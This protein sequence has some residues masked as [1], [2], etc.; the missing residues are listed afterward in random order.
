MNRLGTTRIGA[1]VA[2]LVCVFLVFS[3]TSA[4]ALAAHQLEGSFNGSDLPGGVFRFVFGVTTDSSNGPSE[5]DLYVG[6]IK[7]STEALL[8]T[9]YKFDEDGAYAGVELD[10]SNT[11]GGSFS[12][13]EPEASIL[14]VDG[15]AVDGSAGPTRGD[16]YVADLK[17][18]VVDRF[19]ESGKY[20]CQITGTPKPSAS[21]C[22]GIS[23]SET[24]N[25]G[26]QPTGV[27]VDESTGTV[28]VVDFEHKVIDKFSQAGAFIGQ[29]AD[30]HLTRPNSIDLDSSGNLYVANSSFFSGENVVKFD[31]T[32][33]FDS[34]LDESNPIG[35]GVDRAT[36]HVYVSHSFEGGGLVEYDAAGKE[37]GV[38]GNEVEG[39][40]PSL[41]VNASSGRIYGGRFGAETG[42]DIYAPETTVPITT[43]DPAAEVDE[44]TATIGGKIDPAEGGPVVSC[45][46]EYGPT[47]A[48]GHKV[49]C[50]PPPPYTS[51]A[52]VSAVLT[53]LDPSTT[54]HFRL[55]AANAGAAPYKRG[56]NRHSPD[57]IFITK[58][59][60]T[61][62]SEATINMERTAAALHATI[63]PHGFDTEFAFEYVDDEHFEEGGG[64]SS[65]A[66]RS[67]LY[68]Q[69][70]S[71]LT[72]LSVN[73]GIAGLAVGT[74]YHF[75]A[76]AKSSRG[77]VLGPDQTFTT[78]PVATIGHEAAYAHFK[79]ASAEAII[80]PLGLDTSCQVQFAEEAEYERSGYSNAATQ[81]CE[82]PIVAGSSEHRGRAELVSLQSGL[83]YHFRFIAS[84]A[85]GTLAG[86]DHTFT[87]F[88]IKEFSVKVIDEE[89]QPFTQAGGHPFATITHF[90]LDHSF[91][92]SEGGSAA[93]LNAFVKDV[94]TETPAGRTGDTDATPRCP[95]Y[96]VEE[97]RCSGD[98][99][100]GRMTIEYFEEGENTV[101]TRTRPIFNVAP[102]RGVLSRYAN[103]DPYTSSDARIRSGSD[104]GSTSGTF[105]VSEE[106]RVVGGT[107][108]LWGVP[109]AHVH[110]PQRRCPDGSVGCSTGSP[111][112]PM[113]RNP[114]SCTGP[115][116]TKALIDTWGAPGQ[117]IT[118][119]SEEPATTG[120]DQLLFNPSLELQPTT[121]V[122]D[123]PSGLQLNIH[124]PQNDDPEG[125][126]SADLRTSLISPAAGL[127]I[128]PAV[129]NGLV[130]CT[131]AQADLHGEGPSQ[132]PNASKVGTAEIVTPSLDHPLHGAIFVASPHANPFDSLFA[133][134][135]SFHDPDSGVVV[136]LAG[137][138]DTEASTGHLTTSFA[139]DPQQPFEDFSLNFFGGPRAAL[140]TPSACGPAH[141]ESTL[142]P[143]SAPQSG[144]PALRGDY[145]YIGA[146]PNGIRC[147]GD[148]ADAPHRPI[149]SAGTIDPVGG[150]YTPFVLHLH[151]ED[152]TQQFSG[153][154]LRPPPGLLGRIAGI[155][156]CPDAA[157]AAARGKS[158]EDEQATS[159]CPLQ[160]QV[161]TVSIGVGAGSDPYYVS[162]RAYLA[163]PYKGDPVSLAV[164]V[165]AVAGPYDLGTVIV[166]SGLNVDL[167]SG[168]IKVSTDPIPTTLQG[169]VLDVRSVTASFDRRQFTLNPTSCKP[170]A[171][172]ARVTS[173]FNREASVGD[174]FQL[175]RCKRLDFSPKL[176]LRLFGRTG[177]G[178]HP[179][180][181][182]VLTM[183]P[184]SAN[185][186]RVSM[187][188]PS[189]EFLDNEHILGVCTRVQFASATCPPG[190]VYGHAKA[191]TPLL[192]APLEG[193]VYMRS[194]DH[195]LPDLVAELN[196]QFRFA[197]DSRV[198]GALGGI[199]TTV[200]DLPDAPVSKFVLTMKGG[201]RGILQNSTNI[202]AKPQQALI[203][204]EG[205][206][207][208]VKVL[209]PVLRAQCD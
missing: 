26:F 24:P 20:L 181:R 199:Q 68:S 95:G 14:S 194:S 120:C 72:A 202:C 46:F 45:R 187:T 48:Y 191:W 36:G 113:F 104:Y 106:A 4:S 69:L 32:G 111:I 22:N 105:N 142:T 176:G 93:S 43:V 159:S 30:S 40:Y 112:L 99:Q 149:L 5:G 107:S 188:M 79:S 92:P 121:S 122:A 123:S 17:H 165:P 3:I 6:E 173:V 7:E 87:T 11:P 133:I 203:E 101:S 23:G 140:R 148:P 178:S 38:F 76:V 168:Q 147:V 57:G 64:Y 182:A 115:L 89:G 190:S 47:T 119:T 39:I 56:V 146:A 53:E 66:T 169:V 102:P 44:T 156:P 83:T 157:L 25:S 100:I 172:D 161:G 29:I 59:P 144:P 50:A 145:F 65:P 153:L 175:G 160:S 158:G 88:G 125:V 206:N 19:D 167:E 131:A 71:G 118:A 201:G 183:P 135:V 177:R 207:G 37:L 197:L 9:I 205:Q 136:K 67:T 198:G 81:P 98:S 114:T 10:G 82:A 184:H 51:P 128:N 55:S 31:S 2:V 126:S 33:A 60:P 1:A 195:R 166:R 34:V 127:A 130:G 129:A 97:E 209:H 117:F 85:S 15:I 132:C 180:F 84:N 16:L 186:A 13:F 200:E 21:E 152:G 185:L 154:A 150:A 170:M 138:I 196:G 164:V 192:D 134:Y 124:I 174:P 49:P 110:D 96:M 141:T 208:K 77:S 90:S 52:Q 162:G 18:D 103:Y 63:N 86:G 58:G 75:R 137:R 27:A 155:P 54:Y 62:D 94:M 28:Y 193:P 189:S 108:T 151:R 116:K 204:L 35:L 41:A 42:V 91:V 139:N 78:T 80:D 163:G 70:G 179:S 73:Q 171:V 61:V 12:L 74:T 109:G 8:S 143:W